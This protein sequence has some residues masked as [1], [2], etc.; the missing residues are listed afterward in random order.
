MSRH[1]ERRGGFTSNAMIKGG[2]GA[3]GIDFNNKQDRFCHLSC[4]PTVT[5]GW[6]K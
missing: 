3:L 6:K 5:Q 2:G 1:T 4:H